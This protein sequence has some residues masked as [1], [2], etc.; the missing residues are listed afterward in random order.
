MLYTKIGLYHIKI[1]MNSIFIYGHFQKMSHKSKAKSG[2]KL[3]DVFKNLAD[4]SKDTANTS[5]DELGHHDPKVMK[6]NKK[7]IKKT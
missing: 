1:F 5:A 3:K 6:L 2:G 4:V 7:V